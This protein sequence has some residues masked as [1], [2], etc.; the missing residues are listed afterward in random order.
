MCLRYAQDEQE[1]EDFLHDGFIKVFQNIT[2]Y[3]GRGALGGWIRQVVLTTILQQLRKRP[4]IISSE[5]LPETAAEELA[6]FD[7]L[8][9]PISTQ[10]ILG[11]LQALPKGYRLVFNLYYLEEKSHQEI[12]ALLGISLGSSKSQ[13]FKAKR[14]LRQ[15]IEEHYPKAYAAIGFSLLFQG[16]LPLLSILS[17]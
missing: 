14:T 3:E 2:Q 11:L 12:A 16:M 13:L 9:Q 4:K 6:D 17:S 15:K 8:L 1:A 10:Q 7:E 5:N